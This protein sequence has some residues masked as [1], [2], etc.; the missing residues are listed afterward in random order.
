MQCLNYVVSMSMESDWKVTVPVSTRD[1]ECVLVTFPDQTPWLRL[2]FWEGGNEAACTHA[3]NF[4][5]W[6]PG[7]M[8]TLQ[9]FTRGVIFSGGG[10][11]T[12]Y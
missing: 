8:A 6:R 4:R 10:R 7:K 1:F 11:G 9:I 2:L 3:H 5:K 12:N